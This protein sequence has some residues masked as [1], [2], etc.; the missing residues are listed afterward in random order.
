M[1]KIR[2][3]TLISSIIDILIGLTLAIFGAII[4][5]KGVE[6]P[7]GSGVAEAFGTAFAFIILIALSIIAVCIGVMFLGYG[8]TFLVLSIKQSKNTEK[9]GKAFFVVA[10]I[11]Y[12]VAVVS[13]IAIIFNSSAWYAFIAFSAIFVATATLKIVDANKIKK[14]RMLEKPAEQ[15][16]ST[17][18]N[19]DVNV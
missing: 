17:N 13:L 19:V 11:E 5:M 6:V 7:E 16:S 12:V 1:K 18:A 3:L 9:K 8:L 10:I 14:E 15:N 4:L 2:I